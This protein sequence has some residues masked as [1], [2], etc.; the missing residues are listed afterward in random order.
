MPHFFLDISDIFVYNS[1]VMEPDEKKRKKNDS[2]YLLLTPLVYSKIVTY[3]SNRQP[4]RIRLNIKLKNKVRVWGNTIKLILPEK[5]SELGPGHP[6]AEERLLM[7]T[8]LFLRKNV[9]YDNSPGACSIEYAD[10]YIHAVRTE[11]TRNIHVF[12]KYPEVASGP[13]I[14]L[15]NS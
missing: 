8:E 1:P 13:R 4:C 12:L 6:P 14:G 7:Y 5:A 3:K 15:L 2:Y 10:D 11:K 9:F